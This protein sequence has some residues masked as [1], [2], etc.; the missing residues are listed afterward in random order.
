MKYNENLI[1]G[2]EFVC[3]STREELNAYLTLA[4][5]LVENKEDN[6]IDYMI[7]DDITIYV[8][9]RAII[10]TV[11]Y[12]TENELRGNII[13]DDSSFNSFKQNIYFGDDAQ[14]VIAVPTEYYEFTK[15]VIYDGE[16]YTDYSEYASP[17]D[18]HNN[19]V[20]IKKQRKHNIYRARN[21]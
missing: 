13:Y 9:Y 15:W 4:D 19:S 5:G 14:S 11:E 7:L 12:R 17:E 10:F 21:R 16:N 20:P 6:S 2:Y 8:V 3:W 1:E 18:T